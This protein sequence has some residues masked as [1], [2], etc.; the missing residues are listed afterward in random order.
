MNVK[1]GYFVKEDVAKFDAAF[2]NLSGET[3]AVSRAGKT[4]YMPVPGP[5]AGAVQR[6]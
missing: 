3:A 4:P 5:R 2:F 6:T 1:G